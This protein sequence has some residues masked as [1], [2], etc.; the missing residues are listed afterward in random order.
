MS[1]LLALI[2]LHGM[3]EAIT[4]VYPEARVI[5]DADDDRVWHEEHAV[6]EH[7]QHLL[8]AW[9]ADMGLT[10]NVT[11][12]R[13]S[14]TLEGEQPGMDVLGFHIRQYRVGQHPSGKGPRGHQRLGFKTLTQ[15]LQFRYPVWV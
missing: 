6:L 5:A 14:H 13:I 10:L 2:A 3:D 11:T 15:L 8:M 4:Q 7:C 1:P 9:L 12:T